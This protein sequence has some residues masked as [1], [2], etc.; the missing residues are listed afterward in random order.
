[1]VTD[2][3]FADPPDFAGGVDLGAEVVSFEVG[4]VGF[5][6]WVADFAAGAVGFADGADG[7]SL[8]E[9]YFWSVQIIQTDNNR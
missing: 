5:V 8:E 6:A 2:V 4:V 7:F 9:M 1:L 3:F